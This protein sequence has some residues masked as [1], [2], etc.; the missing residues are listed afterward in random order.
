[1]SKFS[2]D[3]GNPPTSTIPPSVPVFSVNEN[4]SIDLLALREK[5]RIY[6][7]A[8]QAIESQRSNRYARKIAG[9]ALDHFRC[10]TCGAILE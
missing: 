8:L 5:C 10:G 7:E 9:E 4:I 6:E 1:M 2:F 3:M